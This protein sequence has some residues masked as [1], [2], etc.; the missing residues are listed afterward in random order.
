MNRVVALH[1][2]FYLIFIVIV[3]DLRTGIGLVSALAD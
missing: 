3:I 2:W 1:A